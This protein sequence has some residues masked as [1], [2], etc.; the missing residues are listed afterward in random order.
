M[1]RYQL[2]AEMFIST[3]LVAGR[4]DIPTYTPDAARCNNRRVVRRLITSQDDAADDDDASITDRPLS[5]CDSLQSHPTYFPKHIL[6]YPQSHKTPTHSYLVLLMET[7]PISFQP[8]FLRYLGP[9]RAWFPIESKI[10]LSL[11]RRNMWRLYFYN[12]IRITVTACLV[13]LWSYK[14]TQKLE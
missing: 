9:F 4:A 13:A 12:L 5:L 3:T 10:V 8:N 11:S 1:A 14:F 6:A 7:I 2:W